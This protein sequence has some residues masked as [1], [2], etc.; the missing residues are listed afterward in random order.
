ME[1]GHWFR[2]AIIYGV[3]I[4]KF[5]DGNGDGMGDFQ[6]LTEKLDYF[7]WLGVNT[8][9][10]LPFFPSP[11]RDNGYD[12]KDYY[13][14]N[15][16]FGTLTDFRE[17]MREAKKRE[18]RVIIDLVLHH[19]SDEHPWFVASAYGEGSKY[20]DY[21]IWSKE[22]PA[23]NPAD[24]I[25]PGA[26]SSTW[27]Y[28]EGA[29]AHY[30]HRFY[31]FQPDLKIRN[32]DVQQEIF[33]IMDF[34][35]SFGVDGFRLDALSHMIEE[36]GL[37]GT[38]VDNPGQ[39]ILKIKD[40]IQEKYASAALLAEADV[41]PDELDT[42][43]GNEEKMDML[44]NFIF[45]NYLFLAM[46]SHS[47]K[48]FAVSFEKT[49]IPLD[50]CQWVNFIRNN[51]EVDLERLTEEERELVMN[52]FAPDENMRIYNRG[53]RR[54]FAAMMK[55]ERSRMELAFSILFSIPGNPAIMYG[56]EIGMGD[57]LSLPERNSVRT[58]M[59]WSAR[60]NAGF[61]DAGRTIVPVISS[62]LFSYRKINVEDQQKDEG[63]FLH[64]MKKLIRMRKEH[65]K[66]LESRVEILDSGMDE[67]LLIRFA[68]NE[69]IL[70]LHNLSPNETK[71]KIEGEY[72]SKELQ[73]IFSPEGYQAKQLN[74]A[75]VMLPGYGYLWLQTVD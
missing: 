28:H 16:S 26:E 55:G 3:D 56:D 47:A 48:P 7:Q 72:A 12:V 45:N 46:A 22:K 17:F 61:S 59:Q 49:T 54:R 66:A 62:G 10:L 8:L 13:S 50:K 41:R 32:P 31:H 4:A 57:D 6:G 63:S 71:V 68:N 75:E 40:F 37:P 19:T 29:G 25:F 5:K 60:A 34:W 33:S 9:W 74:T 14:I 18:L 58:P 43:I 11:F 65:A 24:S 51:D 36:K 73:V 23:E 2:E 70:T 64:W 53:I 15:P 20:D 35:L 27:E 52:E 42:F 1:N 30:F 38:Q 67:V 21:Y 69:H 44:F 39:F